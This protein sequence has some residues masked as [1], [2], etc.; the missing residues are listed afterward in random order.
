MENYYLQEE[1]MLMG[2]DRSAKLDLFT[3]KITAL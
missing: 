2:F 3:T 1:V